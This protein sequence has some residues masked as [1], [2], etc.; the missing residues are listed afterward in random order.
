MGKDIIKTLEKPALITVV[1]GAVNWGL[2][3]FNVNLVT[4]LAGLV[5]VPSLANVVYGVVGVSGLLL[6]PM[7]ARK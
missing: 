2:S 7:V 1:V 5:G 4:G 6:I 3:L